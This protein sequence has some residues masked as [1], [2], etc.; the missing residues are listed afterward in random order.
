[1]DELNNGER[2]VAKT[3]AEIR[4][5]HVARYEFAAKILP[6]ESRIIDYGC[7]CGYGSYLLATN[8]H[9]VWAI[10][11]SNSALDFGLD[12]WDHPNIA[13]W[14]NSEEFAEDFTD[15]FADAVVAFEVIE[16]I[17]D[18]LPILKEFA[19]ISPR[20]IVS[21]PNEEVFPYIGYRFHYRHYT[22]TDA[23]KL[24]NAA[25]WDVIARF[26][27]EGK[28]SE[29][30]PNVN[31]R[32]LV[33]VC[34]R[35]V[36]EIGVNWSD[37]F[38][39]ML[40]SART[41]SY[42]SG[43][44]DA[45]EI[46][47]LGL[48]TPESVAI[49]GLGPSIA[50]YLDLAKRIG[51]TSKVA[52]EIWGINAL[53]DVL[54]CHRIFHMDDVRVQEMRAAADPDGNIA[55]MLSWLKTT[56]IPVYTSR[57]VPG[58]DALVE[59]PLE[60]VLNNCGYAYFNSTAAYAVAYAIYLGVKKIFLFGCDFHYPDSASA[61]KGRACVEFWLGIAAARGIQFVTAKSS[62]LMDAC[63][64]ESMRLYGYDLVDV[65]IAAVEREEGGNRAV[66]SFYEKPK[67]QW[68]TAEEIEDAYD[69]SKPTVDVTDE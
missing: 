69:H 17:K 20:L 45:I 53:G 13:D 34:E 63:Y 59:F 33:L 47:S 62:T 8:C 24:L 18:P 4:R 11:K 25:G 23:V 60:D 5:D 10:D 38:E 52:D 21:V 31:G 54:K 30:E 7:G 2:Q 22:F 50:Q 19:R 14:S 57:V 55:A 12:T 43:S 1:M 32:T 26:G 51:A 27:Q 41:I 39:I 40:N 37:E 46:G 61:E 48:K 65:T 66:V 68:P 64:P 56:N 35:L 67:E 15:N 3:M 28:E 29:V 9:Y 42:N 58:Y 49:L 6:S 16:H 36:D 44:S